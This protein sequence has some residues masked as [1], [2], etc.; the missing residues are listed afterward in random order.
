MIIGL[1][2]YHQTTT[3]YDLTI[4][5]LHAYYIVAGDT[6]VLVHNCT[7]TVERWMLPEEHQAMIDTGKVQ[8]GSG[9][10]V[11]VRCESSGPGCVCPPSCSR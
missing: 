10:N 11:N 1:R 8:A 2:L 5:G 4:N 6:P 9:G 7:T 3:T